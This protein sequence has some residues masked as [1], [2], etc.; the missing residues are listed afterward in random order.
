M[1]DVHS[2]SIYMCAWSS[3]GTTLLT[4]SA[5]GTVK[6]IDAVKYEVLH[7]WDVP[8]VRAR[9]AGGG[10]AGGGGAT[11]TT[12]E[13]GK[14]P[15]GRMQMGCAFV[16]GDVPVT[17][18]LN[19]EIVALPVPPGVLAGAN[20]GGGGVES[21]KLLTGHQSAISALALDPEGGRMYT[22]DTDGVVCAWDVSSGSC[23]ALGRAERVGGEEP[24]DETLMNRVHNGAITAM[25]HM[26][27][28]L[29]STG[30][31]D[32]MR[33]GDG[34]SMGGSVKLEAQ[35]NAMAK[36]KELGVVVTV[37]GLLLV[38]GDSVVSELISIPYSALSVC[39]S[40]DDRTV[41]VG[42]EDCN[43]HVY[44]VDSSAMTLNEINVIEGGHLKPIHALAISN[45]SSLLAS[46]DVRDICVWNAKDGFS[47]II[48]KSRWC[49]H[50]Q[51][52]SCLAWSPDD[53]VLASGGNDDSIYLWS[54]TKKM[55][56]VHY[57]FA[58]RG[59][60]SGLEFLP[61]SGAGMTLVSVG[62]D[63]CA[64]LWD[65]TDDVAKKFG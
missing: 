11:Q 38:K 61:Q 34:S 49:F 58:H 23:D 50:T 16:T 19:G 27:G 10:P 3:D 25:V 22:G 26:G 29:L 48:G 52:I 37:G 24:A 8:A 13:G 45:D 59:G 7:E 21:A 17:M 33:S 54:L 42:G 6:L 43:I 39:V 9:L 30:W 51:P 57:S 46:A 15:M 20:G 5:D 41:F 47:P 1:E 18:G 64:N 53:T 63:G 31:D 40:S 14:L 55:K 35:P 2:N 12:E 36:G 44:T 4:G 56:R 60:V 32:S 65:V 62:A 28:T